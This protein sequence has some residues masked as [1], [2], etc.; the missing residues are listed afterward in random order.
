MTITTDA[1]GSG[2]GQKVDS[3]NRAHTFSVTESTE[4]MQAIAEKKYSVTTGLVS[5]TT[6]KSALVIVT[7]TGTSNIFVASNQVSLFNQVGT[8]TTPHTIGILSNAVED[9][10][11]FTD[12]T[13]LNWKIGSARTALFKVRKGSDTATLKNEVQS[14]DTFIEDPLKA[15][16]NGEIFVV[17]PGATFSLT[18]TLATGITAADAV[19][20]ANI[21][22][23]AALT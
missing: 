6:G 17:P 1:T 21:F 22:E 8:A 19:F 11:T 10:G 13:L 5:L 20:E 4:T 12:L 14:I 3:D 15:V 23:N 16:A 2:F 18:V 9:T 7:N